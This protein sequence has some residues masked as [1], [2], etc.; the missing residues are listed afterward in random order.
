[1]ANPS[2]AAKEDAA[3]TSDPCPLPKAVQA[4]LNPAA[5]MSRQ[6]E[7]KAR[8]KQ[9]GAGQEEPDGT[10]RGE[11]LLSHTLQTPSHIPQ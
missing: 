11:A 3:P 2:K 4:R 9:P 7:M 6:D 8:E 1:M 10:E 5:E